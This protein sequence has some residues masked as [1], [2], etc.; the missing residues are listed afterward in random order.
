LA[1]TGVRA[2][3]DLGECCAEELI[4]IGPDRRLA[5]ATFRNTRIVTTAGKL[6]DEDVAG[7]FAG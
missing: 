5:S 4:A 6:V 1:G 7:R 3:P 2:R